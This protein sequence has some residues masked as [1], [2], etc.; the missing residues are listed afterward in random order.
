[1]RRKALFKA[2]L[3]TVVLALVAVAAATAQVTGLY[4]QEVAKPEENRV[5]VFNTP[6]KFHSWEQ[7]GDMGPAVT[8]LGG[9]PNGETIV[10]ENET[11]MDLY[12]FKHNL[13]AYERPTPKPAT[14]AAFPASKFQIR[15]FAD[16]SSKSNKDE[17][18]GVKSNDSGVGIDVKRTYFTF[19][20]QFDAKWSAQFQS[21]IGDQG[22]RRFD[23]FVKKAFVEYKPSGMAT[24][25]L[26][27][28]DTPW[29][30]YVEGLY[31]MR[32]LE[33]TI[34]DHLSF[35]SSAEWGFHI[36]GSNPLWGYYFTAGNGRGFS[37]PTRSKTVDFEGRLSF[38]PIKG[39]DLAVGGYSGKRGQ[40]TDA[41][42]AKHTAT[43]QD[44]LINYNSGKFK[45]GGEYFQ[46]KNWNNVTTV[47][48][49]K[50]DGFSGWAQLVVNP[51]WMVFAKY[52]QADP[53][54]DLKPNLQFTYYNAGLQW[55]LN[56]AFQASLAY[57]Y[58][59]VEGGTQSTGN[60]TVGS[61]NP[62]EKGKYNEI[63]IF[64]IY[65]F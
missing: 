53:S 34:T 17:A 39:L 61:T 46:A 62:N 29:I 24:F 37:N 55:T 30:P 7:T 26:G 4:Y 6:E 16:V 58:A 1:M 45:I 8:I 12:L 40:E 21:D 15:V 18:T 48:K 27:S 11:A 49:D 38:T 2:G 35:G 51:T 57:K 50:S 65:N 60:G 19:T 32:Y 10:A 25:R 56:K 20:H 54:K 3:L 28:A 13:P 59:E 42:D 52:D 22:A 33:Q 9:G 31:G 43:R 64:T 41:V 44:A 23:V 47:A 36:T 14:P 5:Y 63:G